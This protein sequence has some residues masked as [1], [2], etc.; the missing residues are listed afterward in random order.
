[1]T[2]DTFQSLNNQFISLYNK[3]AFGLPEWRDIL[4]AVDIVERDP[5][6]ENIKYINLV[7]HAF[8]DLFSHAY[9]YWFIYTAI[10]EENKTVTGRVNKVYHNKIGTDEGEPIIFSPQAFH[11]YSGKTLA[12]L[13][14]SPKSYQATKLDTYRGK[15]HGAGFQIFNEKDIQESLR[16]QFANVLSSKILKCS[17]E[18][19]IEFIKAGLAKS[20]STPPRNNSTA[21]SPKIPVSADSALAAAFLVGQ[22]KG[23]L[24]N[25]I[26]ISN[27]DE[28]MKA[29]SDYI[30]STFNIQIAP[31][32]LRN[33]ENKARRHVEFNP[34]HTSEK[35]ANQIIQ[36]LKGQG[37]LGKASEHEKRY[38][39]TA[40]K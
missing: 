20:T 1:M 5:T 36:L 26:Q 40:S 7:Y 23:D 3:T 30:S 39:K 4:Y 16:E 27:R 38:M 29:L 9:W 6:H 8:S 15:D 34:K 33:N 10:D 14:E 22:E 32:T 11:L 31:G 18:E 12:E 17:F 35:T 37:F 19:F 25:V 24:S 13:N 21:D 28:R 2:N